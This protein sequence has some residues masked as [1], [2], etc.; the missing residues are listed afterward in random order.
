M[1]WK[2]TVTVSLLLIPTAI[3]GL[4][5][6]PQSSSTSSQATGWHVV[7]PGENLETITNYYLGDPAA[8]R[9]NAAL[10]PGVNNP[11]MIFPGQRVKVLLFRGIPSGSAQVTGVGSQVDQQPTPISWR[12]AQR[13]DL[14]RERDGIRTG[15]DSSA[16]LQ[17][18]DGTQV[19]VSEDSLL[20]LRGEATLARPLSTAPQEVEILIGQ[21]D[22]AATAVNAAQPPVEIW[23]GETRAK[24]KPSASGSLST[25]ARRPE[26]G[27]A[28]VMVY[29]GESAVEASGASVEVAAGMGTTV[30]E[31][32]P[33][34]APEPLLDAPVL[35]HPANGLQ[36][37]FAN[38]QFSWQAVPGAESYDIDVCADPSCG[39]LIA[40]ETGLTATTWQVPALSMGSR[41]WRVNAVASN[42]LDGFPSESRQVAI[43]SDRLEKIEPT[44]K[45]VAV[46]VFA[47]LGSALVLPEGSSFDTEI[48]DPTGGAAYVEPTLD[49]QSVTLEALQGDWSLGTH[50]FGGTLVSGQGSRTPLTAVPF[51]YDTVA[52]TIDWQV[53]SLE[54]M[55]LR[56][57]L[58]QGEDQKKPKRKI[59]THRDVP[60]LWSVDGIEW[61]PLLEP[62]RDHAEWAILCDTPQFFLWTRS[63]KPF[64]PDP[65]NAFDVG[66]VLRVEA[67]D[68]HSA[69][70]KLTLSV[71]RVG[72]DYEVSVAAKDMVEN[73]ADQRWMIKRR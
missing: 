58:D 25:R 6:T 16:Q 45:I 3:W 56:H 50:T 70:S 46:G 27:G 9:E 60:L 37:D 47:G 49:G 8:W 17:F 67:R 43:L 42:G 63:N 36:L 28:Q 55:S 12:N 73:A 11:H 66:E 14:L 5:T 39:E 31:A 29:D 71:K 51:I 4:D 18:A 26:A 40:R 72:S 2:Q 62:N 20:F 10:N 19:T 41:W 44:A 15:T 53:G 30:P 33:P 61:T 68:E 32:G 48:N 69:I 7:R 64:G 21:A 59:D 1:N 24:P 54:S 13:E 52:P 38:P 34:S 22:L 57:G 35:G 23:I 65:A